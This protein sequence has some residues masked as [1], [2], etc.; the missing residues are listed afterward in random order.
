MRTINTLRIAALLVAAPLLASAS[1]IQFV[2]V[3]TG[4]NDGVDYVTPYEIKI[5]GTPQ[6]VTCYD[7]YDDVNFGDTW[8]AE[9]LSLK[10]AALTGFFSTDKNALA[11]Y[12]RVAWLDAQSYQGSA[13]QIGVQYAIWSVFGTAPST[14]AAGKYE[15]AADAAAASGYAGFDFSNVRFI[16]Q[17]GGVP[18]K[19]G[20]KQAFV[21]WAGPTTAIQAGGGSLSTPEP[22]TV[23]LAVVG[24]IFLGSWI[25]GNR[26]WSRGN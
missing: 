24:L 25:L 3:P 1:N 10:Q 8:N 5:D 20:T 23:W 18:G 11:D 12:E 15:A 21:Y 6:L 7:I 17:D 9:I 13:Q 19:N 4:V 16:E 14:P 26:I 22:R 2:G